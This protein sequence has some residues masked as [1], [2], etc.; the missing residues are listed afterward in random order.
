[1]ALPFDL[2]SLSRGFA[3]LS[4]AA[5]EIGARSA[6][7][8]AAA[9]GALLG[10]EVAIR[11]RACPGTPAPRAVA[12][13]VGID[14]TA[15]PAF[16]LLEVDPALV[17]G[18]VA[19]LA[20]S[21]AEAGATC[22][23]PVETAALELLA[24]AALDG[25]CGIPAVEEGLAP[26]LCRGVA[27]PPAALAVEL[28]VA[29]GAVAGRARLLVPPSAVR[30]LGGAPAAG[31]ALAAPVP[32]SLRSGGAP[33]APE[34]LEALSPGDVVLLDPPGEAPDALVLPGGARL[35]GRLAD[36]ALHVEEVLVN[37]RNAALPIRLEVE[38]ARI[39]VTLAEIARLEPGAALPLAL[40]RRGVVT[41][42]IG[43]RAVARGE[44]VDVDGAIG[45][46]ILS[47][48]TGP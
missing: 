33:L 6:E 13:R 30:A 35:A 10:R 26:R 14:L 24:L 20:G 19:G 11:A 47:L 27:E 42:R 12:A 41:L 17:V 32:A 23:T 5:R 43:E 4:P 44:L 25:A 38:L 34:E 18:V 22:L 48:E 8:A 1:V 28:A 29:A 39:E 15:L 46:R 40:D 21:S 37:E 3:A 9:L 7:S 16:A 2:P 31:P 36:G 45:V